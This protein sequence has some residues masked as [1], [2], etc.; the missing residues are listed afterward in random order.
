MILE[1]RWEELRNWIEINKEM[2][3][4]IIIRG[5]G[6]SEVIPIRWGFIL[7]NVIDKINYHHL[8]VVVWTVRFNVRVD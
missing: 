5:L 2:T 6:V 3:S 1:E 7:Q 4:S 8:K